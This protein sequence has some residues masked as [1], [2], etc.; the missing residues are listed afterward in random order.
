MRYSAKGT[1]SIKKKHASPNINR[2]IK[3]R[4]VRWAGNIARMGDMITR[5]CSQIRSKYTIQKAR[6]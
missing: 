4:R 3:S 6:S 2:G 1:G 5:F